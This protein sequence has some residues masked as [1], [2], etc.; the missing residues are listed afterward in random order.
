MI[1]KRTTDSSE[2]HGTHVTGI[3][4]GSGYGSID[5]LKGI[6]NQSDLVL[7]QTTFDKMLLYLGFIIF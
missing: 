5:S 2:S 4:S 1:S 6:S 3:A 7:V